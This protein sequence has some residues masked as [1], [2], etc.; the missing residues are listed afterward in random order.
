MASPSLLG[1]PVE[2]VIKI[3]DDIRPQDHFSFAL[4]SKRLHQIS[5]DVLRRHRQCHNALS[6]SS[7]LHPLTVPQLLEKFV[8]D[9]IAAWHIR[10]LEFWVLRR[11]WDQWVVEDPG[12]ENSHS[13]PEEEP[14]PDVV[15]DANDPGR[16]TYL[17]T[18][19]GFNE[20]ESCLLAQL[21]FSLPMNNGMRTQLLSGQEEPLK[22]L[23]LALAP[24]LRSLKIPGSYLEG[25]SRM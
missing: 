25:G 20:F 7:D 11:T 9:A 1:L 2:L 8:F 15:V 3:I 16:A 13:V 22:L 24:R 10:D 19:T 6:T 17:F 23:L 5:D 4:T 12:A 21:G 18:T 14:N